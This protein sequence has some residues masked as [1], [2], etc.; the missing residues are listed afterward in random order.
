MKS[1]L[2]LLTV[3]G[4]SSAFAF[5][6]DYILRTLAYTDYV[7]SWTDV[8]PQNY[9]QNIQFLPNGGSVLTRTF[10]DGKK[11]ILKSDPNDNK[12]VYDIHIFTFYE[13]PETLR[14][15]LV[16]SGWMIEEQGKQ[17]KRLYGILYLYQLGQQ[18]NG[19]PVTFM[20]KAA[21]SGS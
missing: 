11:Q 1:I 19:I 2:L 14:F 8:A 16:L 21:E 12:T 6:Q 15:R 18:M 17:V 4:M 9:E 7:G 3:L 13:N 5:E 10:K 20:E